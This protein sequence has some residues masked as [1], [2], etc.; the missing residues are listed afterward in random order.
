M[1]NL[2]YVYKSRI[3]NGPRKRIEL[4]PYESRL[5]NITYLVKDNSSWIKV[6]E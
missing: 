6:V 2:V 5:S 1:I 4:V 3:M